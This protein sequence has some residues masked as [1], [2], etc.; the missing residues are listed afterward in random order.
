M[1]TLYSAQHLWARPVGNGFWEVGIS[2]YAQQMLGDIVFIESP[3]VGSML[4]AGEVCGVVESVKTATDLYSPLSGEVIAIHQL[5]LDNPELVSD[6]PEQTWLFKLQTSVVPQ[7]LLSRT[8][9]ELLL[10]SA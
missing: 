8:D 7:G 2:D 3:P 4:G 10:K 1:S 5:A 9:Y 6:K